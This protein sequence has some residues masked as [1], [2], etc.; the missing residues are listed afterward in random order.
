ME[1][2]TTTT[3]WTQHHPN[4]FLLLVWLGGATLNFSLSMLIANKASVSEV[5]A[6]LAIIAINLIYI[7]SLISTNG[8]V[9]KLKG[10]RL[11]WLWCYFIMGIIP[12]I[13]ALL[14][15]VKKAEGKDG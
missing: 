4:I 14:P 8:W 7:I 6:G 11:I 13:I 3:S 15:P 1:D 10:R 9:L 12:I 2:K 5:V